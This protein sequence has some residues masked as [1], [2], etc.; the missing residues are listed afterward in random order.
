MGRCLCSPRWWQES[1]YLLVSHL[2][3]FFSSGSSPQ[4]GNVT[5]RILSSLL[6]DVLWLEF[7]SSQEQCP[8]V[9]A[10]IVG[11]N[12]SPAQTEVNVDDLPDGSSPRGRQVSRER[13]KS[14]YVALPLLVGHGIRP[15]MAIWSHQAWK[16]VVV[17]FRANGSLLRDRICNL[18]NAKLYFIEQI[19]LL[20]YIGHLWSTRPPWHE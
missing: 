11:G 17:L 6:D 5:P 14:H 13:A 3:L 19:I 1:H 2:S 15:A 12:A 10:L 16:R 20:Q 7:R 4:G 8:W 9:H 18:R